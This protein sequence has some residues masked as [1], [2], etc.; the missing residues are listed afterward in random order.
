[1]LG[2]NA[3]GRSVLFAGVKQWFVDLYQPVGPAEVVISQLTH[4]HKLRMI[5]NELVRL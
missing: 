4:L 3:F 5:V 2:C 1:V